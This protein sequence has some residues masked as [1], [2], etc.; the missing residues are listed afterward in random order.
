M[1]DTSVPISEKYALTIDEAAAY[2][3]I[4][5]HKLRSLTDR[6][7]S[8]SWVIR[9]GRRILIKRKTF[10]KVLDAQDEV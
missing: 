9:S 2:F 1:S 4:G 8:P 6:S 7:P 5:R 3:G 10:E